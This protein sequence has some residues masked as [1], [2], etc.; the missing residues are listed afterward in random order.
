MSSPVRRSGNRPTRRQREAKA[1]RLVMT[2][3]GLAVLTVGAAIVWILPVGI[4]GL[5]TVVLLAVLT[6]IAGY[7]AKGSLGR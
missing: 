2:T 7:F 5:G 1:Y 3:G 4:I 6:A